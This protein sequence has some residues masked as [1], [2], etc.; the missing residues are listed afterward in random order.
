[1]KRYIFLIIIAQLLSV[2]SL[3][4]QEKVDYRID[5]WRYWKEKA[6]QGVIPF[7]PDTPPKPPIYVGEKNRMMDSPDIVL[8]TGKGI[9][10]SENSV[11]VNPDDNQSVLNANNSTIG[12]TRLGTNALFSFDGGVTWIGDENGVPESISDPAAAISNNGTSYVGYIT[13]EGF[14]QGVSIS[15]DNGATW[16]PSSVATDIGKLDKNHLWVDNTAT[17]PFLGNTYS[18]WTNFNGINDGQ[19]EFSKSTDNGIS[20]TPPISISNNVQALFSNHGVNIQTGPNGEVYVV[21]AIYDDTS[22]ETTKETAIGFSRS[23][24]GGVSFEPATR[25]LNNIQGIRWVPGAFPPVHSKFM[26]TNSFP[27]MTVDLSGGPNN[28]TIY[29]VWA[30]NGSPAINGKKPAAKAGNDISIYMI[31]SQDNGNTW[32]I[33]SRVN[34]DPLG[35]VQYFPWITCDPVTGNLSVIF[36]D[37]RNVGGTD[38]ETWVANSTDGGQ[39]WDEFRVSD[40]SFT[41]A[42]IQGLAGGYMGDYLGISARGG[43]VYPVWTDNRSGNALSY[44]SPYTLGSGNCPVDVTIT[45]DVLS[46]ETDFQ[47]ASGSITATNTLFSGAEASYNASELTFLPG[48]HAQIGSVLSATSVGCIPSLKGSNQALVK[49]HEPRLSSRY[50]EDTNAIELSVFPNPSKGLFTISLKEEI[51]SDFRV[52]IYSMS[53]GLMYANTLNKDELD[54][55]Q[56]DISRFPDGIYILKLVDSKSQKVFTGKVI[57]N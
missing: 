21:W 23:T 2:H 52:E 50:E 5:N 47:E 48:F 34:Q 26:R 9:T 40:V 37:D 55:F 39:T 22:P 30:N 24:D 17:S 41:P 8:L 3:Y 54:N 31:S 18:A 25:I 56:V 38:L 42:P 46:G 1:M 16:T 57:K 36:Y 20:W 51:I 33:P 10:Q 14:N 6:E 28:G 35:N 32:S 11:F 43:R 12:S 19:I 13:E 27:V 49:K 7:N 4:S 45:D 29:L 44:T 15:Y 53:R